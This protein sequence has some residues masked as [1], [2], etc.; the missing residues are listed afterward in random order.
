MEKPHKKLVAWQESVK[1]SIRIYEATKYFPD[2]EKYGLAIQMRRAVVSIASNI[3][4]GAARKGK[5]E[6]QQFL[7]IARGSRSELDTQVEIAYRLDYFDKDKKNEID[8][9]MEKVDRL[10]YGFLKSV[11]K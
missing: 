3:A 11:E 7:N 10:I 4:E 6:L 1:L 2:E 8:A 5:K 9:L